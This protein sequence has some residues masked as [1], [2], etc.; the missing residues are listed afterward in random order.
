MSG[1][2][3]GKWMDGERGGVVEGE[4]RLNRGGGGMRTCA[5]PALIQQMH[6][7]KVCGRPRQRPISVPPHSA[8][9]QADRGQAQT[10]SLHRFMG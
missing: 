8:T 1:L 5:R 4:G 9:W 3:D 6:Q 7:G 10:P 2:G